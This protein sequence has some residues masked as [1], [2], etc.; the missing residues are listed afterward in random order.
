MCNLYS[1]VKGQAAILA[2]ARAMRDATG[3]LPPHPAIFPDQMAPVVWTAPDGV[4]ELTRMRWGFPP[5]PGLGTRPV[6]N[7][8][9]LVSRYWM[10]WTKPERRCLVPAT[11][12]CEYDERASEGTTKG[13]SK[14]P[15]WFALDPSRPLFAF[16][17]LWRPWTGTR[18]PKAAPEEGEHQLFAF[19][20]CPPNAEVA[21]IHP[22]AMPVLLTTPEELEVWLRAPWDEARHLQRPLPDGALQIVADGKRED[23]LD[24]GE[25]P[26]TT[27]TP[28]V[29]EAPAPEAAAPSP[30]AA[31]PRQLGFDL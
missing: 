6:T 20:T 3:N 2:W 7:A 31:K 5:A 26:P 19:A 9:N 17:G 18:G 4:R 1:E 15:M 21:P 23:G 14:R 24:A 8:R 10:P 29:M 11:S 22:K 12:F 16:A 27:A 28:T 30:V 13:P 25:P